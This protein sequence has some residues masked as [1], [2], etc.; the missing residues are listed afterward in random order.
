MKRVGCEIKKMIFLSGFFLI[1]NPGFSSGQDYPKRPISLLQSVAPG[2]TRDMATRV[3][4]GKAE[5]ILGQPFVLSNNGGGAGTVALSIVA[6]EKPDGYRLVGCSSVNL[7]QIPQFRTVPYKHG[8]FVPILHFGAPQ[9][10]TVVRADSP[11]KT[12]KEFVE[13]AKKNPGKI[14]Y[15]TV[16]VNS[17]GHLALE[18]IAR[19]EGIQWTHVPYTGGV[20]AITALLGGHVQAESGT[21]EWIPH[22]KQGTLRLLGTHG[23][24]RMKVFPDIPTFKEQGY[25]FVSE[26]LQIIAAPK[27]TPPP[28]IKRL[29]EAFRKAMDDPEFIQAME[30]FEIEIT[31]RNSEDTRKY[32]E[33]AYER[34][35]RM[36]IDL[37]LSKEDE[38][39]S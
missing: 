33:T 18:Y 17:S 29:E 7:I 23:E 20:P 28:I 27:G 21:S 11:W 6:K 32:L 15:S 5:K 13:Y 26:V 35:R 2:G 8:D 3:L 36:I 37:K 14:S 39:K 31:Y 10:G 19:T 34:L 4:A 30:R 38:R 25:D 24:R 16:G 12:L 22:I 1:L 9:T